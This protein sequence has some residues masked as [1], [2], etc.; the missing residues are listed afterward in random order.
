MPRKITFAPQDGIESLEPFIERIIRACAEVMGLDPDEF[1]ESCWVSDLSAIS[2]FAPLGRPVE[3]FLEE[4]GDLLGVDIER[5][6][7][8]IL[9][10]ARKMRH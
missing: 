5:G 9:D 3:D 6:D 4:V 1:V 2:D 8:L 10:V 7:T